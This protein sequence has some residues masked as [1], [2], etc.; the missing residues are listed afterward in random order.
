MSRSCHLTDEARR[1]GLKKCNEIHRSRHLKRVDDYQANPNHCSKCNGPLSWEKRH[2]KFCDHSCAASKNNIGMDRHEAARLAET[3]ASTGP[4]E[5]IEI[6]R[7]LKDKIG[8]KRSC[9]TCGGPLKKSAAAFCSRSCYGKHCKQQWREEIEKAGYL[10]DYRK[11]KWY[12]AETRGHQ[13]EICKT[14]E[15]MG[16]PVPL[17]L[18]HINGDSDNNRLGNVR[19][20]CHNCNALTP[21][22]CGK[23][24]G[25]GRHTKR[26]RYRNERYANGKSY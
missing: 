9:Q 16:G 8:I 1:N 4:E 6:S 2:N 13:C 17:V 3:L 14:Q 23:N 24:K 19:L 26:G 7:R 22:F 10:I 25:K 21:T 18:D 11:D 20:I 12:L 5:R 15:W